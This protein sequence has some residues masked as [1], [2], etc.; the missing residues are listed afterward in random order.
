MHEKA[1]HCSAILYLKFT[2]LTIILCSLNAK[3]ALADLTVCNGTENALD[4]SV[5]Y[6]SA[7]DWTTQGWWNISAGGCAVVQNGPLQARYYYIYAADRMAEGAWGGPASMCTRAKRFVIEGAND[8][9][10]RGYDLTGFF[11]VDTGSLRD[12][13]VRIT[14]HPPSAIEN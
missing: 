10:A 4:V 13:T 11:E 5:G 9:A 1:V 14:G 7:R 6:K 3:S 12:W 8:C 2:I